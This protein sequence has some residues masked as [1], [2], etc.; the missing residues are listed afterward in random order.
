M[1]ENRTPF[2]TGFTNCRATACREGKV[3]QIIQNP[4]VQKDGFYQRSL[5][6]S[7]GRRLPTTGCQSHTT[8]CHRVDL[9]GRIC[10]P[11]AEFSAKYGTAVHYGLFVGGALNSLLKNQFSG[12]LDA[13]ASDKCW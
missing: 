3:L 2:E 13:S 7:F 4:G 8:A 12:K 11:A 10:E 5:Q 1:R 6:H 9:P